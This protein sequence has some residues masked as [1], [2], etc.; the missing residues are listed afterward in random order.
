MMP[1]RTRLRLSTECGSRRG[2]KERG[3]REIFDTR[4]TT[5]SLPAASGNPIAGYRQRSMTQSIPTWHAVEAAASRIAPYITQT[6]VMTSRTLNERIG[7]SVFFKCENFQRIGAFKAR[8][9]HNAVL[10]MPAEVIQRGVVTHSSGNHAAALALAARSLNIPAYVVMPHN[11]STIKI[12]SVERLGGKITFCEPTTAARE[13]A[14]AELVDATGGTLI[15]P[16]NDWDVIVG[17]GTATKELIE[18]VGKLGENLDSIVAPVGGGGLLSGAAIYSKKFSVDVFG[19]EPSAADDAYQSFRSGKLMPV[20]NPNTIADGLRTSLGD[21]TF[22]V[23]QS[24]V[25]DIVTVTDEEIQHAMMLV[26]QVMKL[27]IEPSSAVPVAALLEGRIL[28]AGQRIGVILSGGNVDL[29]SL[30]W[31]S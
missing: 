31:I 9:A 1:S 27:I 23:I 11:S 4:F 12:Q 16:F 25:S 24:H 21:R 5:P 2:C 13:R 29:K 20:V 26:W 18:Q 3:R 14:A 30:P 15:H 28:N 8:G 17:Q 6:P 19:A 7:A 22:A 10:S